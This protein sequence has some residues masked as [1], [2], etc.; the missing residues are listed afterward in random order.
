MKIEKIKALLH[1]QQHES[2]LDYFVSTGE[3]PDLE[4]MQAME[5]FLRPYVF[6]QIKEH[7]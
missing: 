6:I 4:E 2:V 1:M 5:L 3:N 7:G